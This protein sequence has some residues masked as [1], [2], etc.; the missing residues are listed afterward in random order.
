MD[1]DR[2]R[3]KVYAA[4]RS[5]MADL[6]QPA[7]EVFTGRE[8]LEVDLGFASLERIEFLTRVEQD[9]G[10]PLGVAGLNVSP[11]DVWDLVTL[12]DVIAYVGAHA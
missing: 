9:T 6:G 1:V 4:A 11:V 12:D 8:A 7:P 10:Q 3:Q 5:V 2:I